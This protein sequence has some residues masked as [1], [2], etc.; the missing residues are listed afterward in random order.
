MI[1]QAKDIARFLA[2][3]NKTSE[4]WLWAGGLSDKGYGVF[5]LG[6]K[7]DGKDQY[8]HRVAYEIAYG[9]IPDGLDVLHKCDN[10]TCVNPAHLWAGTH[11][12]NMRDMFA[13]GRRRTLPGEKN[14][15]AK[16]TWE[17]VREIRSRYVPHVVTCK[18]LAGEYGVDPALIHRIVRGRMWKEPQAHKGQTVTADRA[19]LLAEKTTQLLLA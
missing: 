1:I 18:M 9:T 5:W 4:C 19:S 16:L 14:P 3:V 12:E 15:R 6:T 7:R 2:K 13:K 11:T 10:P 17:K 8:A